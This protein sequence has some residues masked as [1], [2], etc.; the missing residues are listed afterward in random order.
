MSR[1]GRPEQTAVPITDPRRIRALAHPI[2]LALLE[3]LLIAG[4]LTA[5]RAAERIGESPTTCSFHL[6]QLAKYGFV[7]EAGGGPGRNRPWRVTNLGHSFQ[8][9]QGGAEHVVAAE[10]LE[11]AV[12]DRHLNRLE[13]WLRTR[14]SFPEEWRGAAGITQSLL[15]VTP[16][17]LDALRKELMEL[18]LRHADRFRDRSRRPPDAVPVE[19]IAFAY[20]L[21]PT[22]E[23]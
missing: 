8:A 20:P 22:R 23:E 17:E 1:S 21:S 14:H 4:S 19:L 5:T 10:A 9:G 16:A 7:E 3:A 2:R 6:R 11:R 15:Y 18:L 13:G 12:I